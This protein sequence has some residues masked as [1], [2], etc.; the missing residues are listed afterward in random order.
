M[1]AK[2]SPTDVIKPVPPGISWTAPAK[3]RPWMQPPKLVNLSDVAQGY[4][5]NLSSPSSMNAL[6]DAVETNVPLAAL[7]EALMLSSVHKG[8][9]SIDTGVLVMPVIIE[10]LV[11]AAEL[12]GIEYTMFPGEGEEEDIIPDRIIREAIAEATKKKDVVEEAPVPK[13]ELSGLM[14]RRTSKEM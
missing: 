11:T 2:L 14:S 13:V 6:L 5:D 1:A 12:H 3:G 10:M 8:V 9:H 4:I 7:A